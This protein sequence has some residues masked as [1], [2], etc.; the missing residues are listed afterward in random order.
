[1][2]Y[3][4]TIAAGGTT[5]LGFNGIWNNSTNAVPASFA[6]NGTACK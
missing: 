1:M 3:N 2:S 6:L 5:S 4:G